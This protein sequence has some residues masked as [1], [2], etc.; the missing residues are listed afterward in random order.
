MNAIL[1][2][3]GI[4]SRMG[5]DQPK[6]FYT[7]NGKPFFI[8]S[9]ELFEQIDEIDKVYVT[10]HEDY[11]DLYRQHIETFRLSKAE[12]VLGGQSRQESVYKA[13]QKVQSD[14]VIIHEAARPLISVDQIRDLMNYPDVD[15]VVPTIP[16]PFTVAEGGDHFERMLDRSKLH[17][18]QLPQLFK[19]AKLLQAHERAEQE[20]FLATEDS[21][22]VHKYGGNV[23]FVEGSES[24]I[25]ITT[26]LD[27]IIVNQL[28]KGSR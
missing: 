16:I 26:Q 12:L 19:T 17:N 22:M 1:L 11:T 28:L 4:G 14:Q 3:A 5:I 21:M 2:A 25:K 18:I 20:G 23:R 6:Q 7:I 27:L 9:L 8:R 10:A 15:G 13:L 24:N